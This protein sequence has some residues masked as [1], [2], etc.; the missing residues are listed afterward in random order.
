MAIVVLLAVFMA[1]RLSNR[2]IPLP[3]TPPAQR[4]GPLRSAPLTATAA[5]PTARTQDAAGSVSESTVAGYEDEDED[6]IDTSRPLVPVPD[7]ADLLPQARYLAERAYNGDG[8]AAH[9]LWLLAL[10]CKAAQDYYRETG[11]E[12]D[13]AYKG[14][15]AH[16]EEEAYATLPPGN[17]T[18]QYWNAKALQARDPMTLA[19]AAIGWD[20]TAAQI[21]EAA[22]TAVA[23]GDVEAQLMIGRSMLNSERADVKDGLAWMLTACADCD[24]N[25]PRVGLVC[26]RATGCAAQRLDEWL[27]DQYGTA[28]VA[29]G[30]ERAMQLRQAIQ[31]GESLVAFVRL[32]PS[33]E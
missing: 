29:E 26:E 6:T 31:R 33:R 28:T 32:Q 1:G 17:Y 13:D 4:S 18:W 20:G 23:N 19:L 14:R 16:F 11:K 7:R 5:K 22:A 10:R 30:R 27:T 8:R 3:P 25:D 9:Y 12:L 24:V 15:C 21:E 2:Y